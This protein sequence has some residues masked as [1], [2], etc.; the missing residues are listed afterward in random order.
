[1]A[2]P[3]PVVFQIGFNRCGTKFITELFQAN[4][5]EA[6]HWGQGGLAEDIFYAKATGQVPLTD[7]PK[8][9]LFSDLESVHRYDRPML[10]AFKEFRFLEE[11]F[12]EAVFLLNERDPEAWA[13]SRASHHDGQYIRFHAHHLGLPINEVPQFWL[14]DWERHISDVLTHFEGNERLIRYNIDSDQPGDL[15]ERLAPWFELRK[16]PGGPGRKI[17]EK[18]KRQLVAL[19]G[20]MEVAGP[21]RGAAP[22]DR[23]FVESVA[24]HCAALDP[25]PDALLDANRH[26]AVHAVWD[27]RAQV[28]DRKGEPLPLYRE[29]G[30]EVDRFLARPRMPKLDRVQGVL[31]EVLALHR[32]RAMEIDMQDGRNLGAD[33]M[34]APDNRIVT[35][36]RRPGAA[37]L[38]LWPLPGYHTIGERHFAQAVTPDPIPF[39]EKKDALAWRGNLAGRALAGRFPEQK[40]RR[41]SHQILQDLMKAERGG[42]AE[43]LL[44]AELMQL[45]RYEFVSRYFG[46]PDFDIG[47]TLPDQFRTLREESLLSLY[48]TERVPL[49]WVY[50]YRYIASLSGHDTGSNFFTAAN[51]NSVV[52]KEE[53]GW[54]LFYTGAFRPWQHYIPLEPGAGDIEE[55]LAWARENPARCAEM[56]MASQAMCTRFACPKFRREFLNL[57]LDTF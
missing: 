12:P 6:R 11:Q 53:D 52:L 8:A 1:M 3:A 13:A 57:I 10:E 42:E 21:K 20:G 51:S 37:N 29:L 39:E 7:W 31:N 36:N 9:R 43:T 32:P 26:S 40:I 41:P 55:K 14:R 16:I 47:F 5:Y 4:G 2:S 25:A 45:T 33:G 27:G 49:S 44:E 50:G 54:E 35:Y 15:A 24:R 18:R 48:C 23:L 38:V 56:V 28:L 34:R 22:I 46:H 19:R 17:R 30:W